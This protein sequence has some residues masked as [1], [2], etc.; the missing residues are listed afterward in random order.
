MS[1]R[2]VLLAAVTG[3]SVHWSL[4][5]TTASLLAIINMSFA[6]AAQANVTLEQ[7]KLALDKAASLPTYTNTLTPSEVDMLVRASNLGGFSFRKTISDFV[8]NNPTKG[9]SAYAETRHLISPAQSAYIANEVGV[10]AILEGVD[11]AEIEQGK[12]TASEVGSSRRVTSA[13]RRQSTA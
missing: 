8:R 5:V 10:S 2:K 4:P 12:L 3:I 13:G 11:I 1:I 9:L 7:I 6:P